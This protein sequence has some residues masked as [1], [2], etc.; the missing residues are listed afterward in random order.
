[1]TATKFVLGPG[2]FGKKS[3]GAMP[4]LP[5][6]EKRLEVPVPWLLIQ[7]GLPVAPGKAATPHVLTKFGSTMVA[8]MS[9][10]S[11]ARFVCLNW[12]WAIPPLAH[13][14]PRPTAV[15]R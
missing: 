1:G 14:A 9:E 10:R 8:P 6:T 3:A 11:D 4:V 15:K 13:S 12:A 2:G 5:V 7:K